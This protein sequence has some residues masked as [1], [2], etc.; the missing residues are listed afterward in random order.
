M[1]NKKR[2]SNKGIKKRLVT[3]QTVFLAILLSMMYLFCHIK[4]TELAKNSVLET[5][6]VLVTGLSNDFKAKLSE[7]T[8]IADTFNIGLNNVIKDDFIDEDLNELVKDLADKFPYIKR[9]GY[10]ITDERFKM[11][12]LYY[13]NAVNALNHIDNFNDS[14]LQNDFNLTVNKKMQIISQ[15]FIN[16]QINNESLF[17]ISNPI[18]YEGQ[19]I[20]V[21][22]IEI[23][24]DSDFNYLLENR[25]YVTSLI[26]L[27]RNDGTVYQDFNKDNIGNKFTKHN[28]LLDSIGFTLENANQNVKESTKELL[29]LS[30]YY[31][32]IDSFTVKHYGFSVSVLIEKKYCEIRI[33]KLLSYILT[34]F[35][36]IMF[37]GIL[38]AYNASQVIASPIIKIS[39]SI[40]ALSTG[41]GDLR[42][43]IDLQAGNEI[44]DIVG[45]LNYFINFL[46][47]MMFDIKNSVNSLTSAGYQIS[48]ASTLTDGSINK[49]KDHLEEMRRVI[50]ML[51]DIMDSSKANNATIKKSMI[52]V[53]GKVKEQS[54]YITESSSAI[55]EMNS[56]INSVFKSTNQK[57][58]LLSALE[59]ETSSGEQVM[60]ETITM[61]A[62]VSK[63]A[64]SIKEMLKVIDNVAEQ[65]NLLA[66]NAAI[67]AAHAGEA[68]RGFKVVADEIRKLAQNTSVSAREIDRS[69]SIV[70][71]QI[72]SSNGNIELAGSKFKS[73][74]SSVEQVV[75]GMEE[76]KAA[77]IELTA[78]SKQI[79]DGLQL[80]VQNTTQL[81]DSYESMT[82]HLEAEA[83]QKEH[84]GELVEET[85]NSMNIVKKSIGHIQQNMN[86][87]KEAADGNTNQINVVKKLVTKFKTENVISSQRLKAEQKQEPPKKEEKDKQ[88]EPVSKGDDVYKMSCDYF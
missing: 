82:K 8:S 18:I 6:D 7:I 36:V 41:N 66:M 42:H 17:R 22:F 16:P 34:L 75:A 61:F 5:V 46:H 87:V 14:F 2:T 21:T 28:E 74:L 88:A 72:E 20:G 49:V 38:V 37:I 43:T 23:S 4:G 30:D 35:V 68:G 52:E 80:I 60:Q 85:R 73:T 84:F 32:L 45:S 86:S 76:T 81:N 29:K 56:S 48:D 33:R 51:S 58:E 63:S 26:T 54:S 57:I 39:E 77:M 31:L 62:Q 1:N 64:E 11:K 27:I 15:P 67:E 71:G 44:G 70:L 25:P 78:G 53:Q 83:V 10:N 9:L 19:A 59:R 79:I 69:V 40:H 65:T 47:D 12:K 55:E 3:F 50:Q 24:L 13:K